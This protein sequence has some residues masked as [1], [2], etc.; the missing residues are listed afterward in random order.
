M[1]HSH[2]FYRMFLSS[3]EVALDTEAVR[4]DANDGGRGGKEVETS[5]VK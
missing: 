1:L 3:E 5:L 2:V 4:F